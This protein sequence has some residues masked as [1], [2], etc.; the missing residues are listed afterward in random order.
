MFSATTTTT[1]TQ[2]HKSYPQHA[3]CLIV[4]MKA[5]P[6]FCSIRFLLRLFSDSDLGLPDPDIADSTTPRSPQPVSQLPRSCLYPEDN[7][8]FVIFV[9]P[10]DRLLLASVSLGPSVRPSTLSPPLS[11]ALFQVLPIPRYTYPSPAVYQ[12]PSIGYAQ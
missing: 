9:F 2:P 5:I 11:A 7:D 10:T 6:R 1:T 8:I 4:A 12:E 3:V